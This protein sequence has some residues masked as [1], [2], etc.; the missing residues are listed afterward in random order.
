MADQ[1]KSDFYV[2]FTTSLCAFEIKQ[3]FITLLLKSYDFEIAYL[4]SKELVKADL[5]IWALYLTKYQN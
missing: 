5:W 2:V 3:T 4:G 1:G